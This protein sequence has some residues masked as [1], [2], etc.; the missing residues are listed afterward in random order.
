MA[1]IPANDKASKTDRIIACTKREITDFYAVRLAVEDDYI[2][3]FDK[4]MPIRII[5]DWEVSIRPCEYKNFSKIINN[6]PKSIGRAE[7][8]EPAK[9]L[10]ESGRSLAE[11]VV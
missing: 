5:L 2:E 4:H 3:M 9:Y 8:R 6:Q 1:F 10:T 7:E 11:V